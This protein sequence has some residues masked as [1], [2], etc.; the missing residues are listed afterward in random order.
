MPYTLIENFTG[1]VDRTRKRYAL[2]GGTLWECINAH[3]SRGGDIEKR[4]AF[5]PIYSLPA[6]T[7]GLTATTAGL[8]V[9]GIAAPSTVTV[10]LGTP[11]LAYFQLP[12]PSGPLAM[13]RIASWDLFDGVPYV[14]AQYDNGDY[15]HFYNFSHVS[16]WGAG[17]NHPDGYG[18]I[19]RTHR[20]KTYSPIG[21]ILWF[22]ELEVPNNFDKTDTGSGFVNVRNH[23]SG[24]DSITGMGI[25]ANLLPIFARRVIQ[26]W[27]MQNDDAENEPTQFIHDTGTRSSR[28]VVP[29]GDYDCVYLSDSGVR[30]LRARQGTNLAGVNDVG[31]AVDDLIVEYMKTLSQDDIERAVAIVEPSDGRFML[32]L[33][34]RVFVFSYFPSK[35]VSAWSWYEP[36]VTFTDFVIFDGKLYARAGDIIYVY[37]GADGETYDNSRVTV[38]LPFV[39]GGKPGHHRDYV[40]MDIAGTGTW[41]AKWLVNPKN[42]GDVVHIGDLV[43][44]TFSDDAVVAG[45]GSF[46]H[47]APVLTHEASGPA[48]LSQI[49]LHYSGQDPHEGG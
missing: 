47:V 17:G 11:G 43:G 41:S 9:Y 40:N 6:G 21:S 44:V 14:I 28:S 4:K 10:P 19:V 13:R 30:S 37:G 20:L 16:T 49:A 1:G 48:T 45:L 25:F 42:D 34:Q 15:R 33:G 3:I 5:Q 18:S 38:G 8:Q 27:D 36:G 24:S 22:S 46:S 39:S 26:I 7:H 32:A 23:Q 29:Y 31:T 35:K 2:P 12:H